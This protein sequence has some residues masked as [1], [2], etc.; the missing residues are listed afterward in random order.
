MEIFQFEVLI[1]VEPQV[2]HLW[3]RA[4]RF[5]NIMNDCTFYRQKVV[6]FTVDSYFP[7]VL[8]FT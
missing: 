3:V 8:C 5:A 2:V 7:L 1:D 6:V 4:V